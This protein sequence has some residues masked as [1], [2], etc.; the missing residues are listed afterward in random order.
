MGGS[1]EVWDRL[2][3]WPPRRRGTNRYLCGYP[4]AYFGVVDEIGAL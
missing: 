3:D 1:I 2:R 4:L